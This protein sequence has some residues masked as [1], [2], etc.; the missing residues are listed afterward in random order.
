MLKAELKQKNQSLSEEVGRLQGHVTQ[1]KYEYTEQKKEL[2]HIKSQ[3]EDYK[4]ERDGVLSSL[5]VLRDGEMIEP[6]KN[7]CD[8]CG[9]FGRDVPASY[10]KL[11]N[12]MQTIINMF[13]RI[14]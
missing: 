11:G 9:G 13:Q 4:R 5:Y 10:T 1:L 2:T 12:Q 8:E 6:A 7:Q 14:F 3:L